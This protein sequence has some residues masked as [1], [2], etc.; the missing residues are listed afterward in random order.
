MIRGGG[1]GGGGG[2][3]Y[4]ILA[5]AAGRSGGVLRGYIIMVE[6]SGLEMAAS[7]E[8]VNSI[9]LNEHLNEEII[10]M[11]ESGLEMDVGKLGQQAWKVSIP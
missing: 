5:A 11:E 4:Q 9:E 2:G 3:G 7:L 1:G 10:M 6:E 8:S